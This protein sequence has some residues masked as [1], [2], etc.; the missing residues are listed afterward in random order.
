MA[1]EIKL[2]LMAV[3]LLQPTYKMEAA[4]PP[5]TTATLPKRA[6]KLNAECTTATHHTQNRQHFGASPDG[7]TAA[8][9]MGKVSHDEYLVRLVF[10]RQFHSANSNQDASSYTCRNSYAPASLHKHG[11]H[12]ERKTNISDS[13]M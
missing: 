2:F 11:E 1:G 9:A 4:A 10:S 7:H 5:H 3:Q 12:G 8:A 6:E 13:V